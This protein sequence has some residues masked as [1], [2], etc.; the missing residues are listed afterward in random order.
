M[1][2]ARLKSLLYFGFGL[3]NRNR[4]CRLCRGSGLPCF[5]I[6]IHEHAEAGFSRFCSGTRV[7]TILLVERFRLL[8]TICTVPASS[9]FVDVD[10][11]LANLEDMLRVKIVCS[12]AVT[13]SGVHV[14]EEV[15]LFLRLVSRKENAKTPRSCIFTLYTACEATFTF[16]NLREGDYSDEVMIMCKKY[17][18]DRNHFLLHCKS[19]LPA[20]GSS[21][22][23]FD[24]M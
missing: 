18:E 24:I 19:Y 17:E 5:F 20:M 2:D 1:V 12:F 22:S 13:Y 14:I 10:L 15:F 4:M 7:F 23:R 21:V 16:E 9:R 6:Q 11:D 8:L 3:K